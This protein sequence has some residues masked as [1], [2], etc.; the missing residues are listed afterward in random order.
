MLAGLQR[1]HSAVH[2]HIGDDMT[3]RM[4]RE[5]AR[6]GDVT[7]T[8]VWNSTHD[9]D[10]HVICPDGEEVFYGNKISRKNRAMLDV[11]MNAGEPYSS[12]PVENIF[13]GDADRGEEAVHGKYRVFVQNFGYHFTDNAARSEVDEPVPAGTEVVVQGYTRT[14]HLN[15]TRGHVRSWEVAEGCYRV[16]CRADGL[17]RRINPASLVRPSDPTRP[18]LTPKCLH[19]VPFVCRLLINDEVR[20]F[21]GVCRGTGITLGYQ[22]PLN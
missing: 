2:C 11:D 18:L 3:L 12:E 4:Q 13:F 19:G 16:V 21:E 9:L 8:L 15:G 5:G 20:E 6:T 22:L 17:V 1:R 10:L 7:A 14:P